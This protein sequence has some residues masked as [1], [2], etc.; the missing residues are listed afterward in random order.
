MFFGLQ[1]LALTK[2]KEAELEVTEFKM[3]GFFEVTKMARIT[4]EHNQRDSTGQ[5]FLSKVKK[6][7]LRWFGH[8]QGRCSEYI[9][10]NMLNME[11]LS[12]RQEKNQ[13]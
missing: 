6:A 5:M 9:G 7:R 1:S 3:L 11:Q 12:R 10:R 2:T 8:V 4:N 13:R